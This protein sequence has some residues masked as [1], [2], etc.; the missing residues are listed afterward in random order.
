MPRKLGVVQE[1]VLRC[2]LEHEGWG[3]QC[4]WIWNSASGTE[5]IIRTLVTRGLVYETTKFGRMYFELTAAG[6][7]EAERS[8]RR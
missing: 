6:H 2:L 8:R 3:P 4:G 1:S 7:A 5:K